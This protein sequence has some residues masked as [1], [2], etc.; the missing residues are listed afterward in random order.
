MS[1]LII[2]FCSNNEIREGMAKFEKLHLFVKK[3][4]CILMGIGQLTFNTMTH[5]QLIIMGGHVMSGRRYGISVLL[6]I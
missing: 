2:Q 1:Y 4:S 3:I 6:F 5:S